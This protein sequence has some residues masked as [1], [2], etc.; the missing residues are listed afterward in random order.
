MQRQLYELETEHDPFQALNFHQ[1]E[2]K[3]QECRGSQEWCLLGEPLVAKEH[4]DKPRQR[5]TAFAGHQSKETFKSSSGFGERIVG[6]K[7]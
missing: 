6:W 4:K 3:L 1:D 7:L 5:I 2:A